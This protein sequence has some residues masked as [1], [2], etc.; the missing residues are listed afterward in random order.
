MK[1]IIIGAVLLG[2]L[3][4][5]IPLLF[6]MRNWFSDEKPWDYKSSVWVSKD[7]YFLLTVDEEQQATC[8][9]GRGTDTVSF[10]VDCRGNN[11]YFL[12]TDENGYTRQLA[13]GSGSYSSK[14]FV[15][16]FSD[17]FT[18]PGIY[19]DPIYKIVFIRQK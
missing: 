4:I 5:A 14:R 9:A 11:V 2:L 17:G 3:I 7:P 18:I 10:E 8:T 12:S 1:K 19:E 13:H 15:V 6:A 16:R